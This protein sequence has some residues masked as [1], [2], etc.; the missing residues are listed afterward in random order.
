MKVQPRWGSVCVTIC[1]QP[2][3]YH[4]ESHARVLHWTKRHFPPPNST[5]LGY[6]R[7][8]KTSQTHFPNPEFQVAQNAE[9]LAEW[10]T[11][12][13]P[14]TG[15]IN[16]FIYY[17]VNYPPVNIV[18]LLLG[19]DLEESTSSEFIIPIRYPEPA[20]HPAGF[21]KVREWCSLMAKPLTL[22]IQHKP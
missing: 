9:S 15:G 7:A 3:N 1:L 11:V 6:W 13:L 22:P 2:V 19:V 17:A 8:T 20:I 14:L 4:S 18:N 21:Y 12:S 16:L 10:F 5:I